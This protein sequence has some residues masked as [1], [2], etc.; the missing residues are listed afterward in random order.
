MKGVAEETKGIRNNGCCLLPESNATDDNLE[1]SDFL[2]N[3]GSRR[4]RVMVQ[5]SVEIN[6]LTRLV[7]SAREI[8]K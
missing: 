3:I 4:S 6:R 2:I 1:K 5:W 8:K 7:W